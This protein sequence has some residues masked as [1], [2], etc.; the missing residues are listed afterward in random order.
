MTCCSLAC[1]R[2][3]TEDGKRCDIN[4][5]VLRLAS[6][7]L[8]LSSQHQLPEP[9]ETVGVIL[10]I[11]EDR[12]GS[13]RILGSRRHINMDESCEIMIGIEG[14]DFLIRDSMFEHPVPRHPHTHTIHTYIYIWIRICMCEEKKREGN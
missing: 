7:I 1:K 14:F 4:R 10:R 3:S 6:D 13:D 5:L 11:D 9:G 2:Y 12:R 8:H